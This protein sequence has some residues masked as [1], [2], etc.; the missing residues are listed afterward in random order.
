MIKFTASCP[1]GEDLEKLG[2]NC[3]HYLSNWLIING[4]LKPRPNVGYDTFY[5]LQGRIT[6]ADDMRNYIFTNHLGLTEHTEPPKNGDNC[7]IYTENPR[8]VYYG[9][10]YRAY[11]GKWFNASKWYYF[12]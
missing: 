7:F 8:H 12:Y 1:C 2:G 9:T 5:C 3:A 10:K 6:R 4:K 11:A